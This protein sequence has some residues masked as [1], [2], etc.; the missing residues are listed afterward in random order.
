MKK[1]KLTQNKSAIVDDD[2]FEYLSQW[3]WRYSSGGYVVRSLAYRKPC[4]KY[5][6][7]SIYMHRLVNG[8]PKGK[9]TDHINGNKKDNRKLNLR[10]CTQSQNLMN[11]NGDKNTSSKYKGV[12]WDKR[13][14]KWMVQITMK[15]KRK[16]LGRFV[17]EIDAAK[18]YDKAAIK[19]HREFAKT[20]FID[21]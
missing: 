2:D 17:R 11:R 18:A 7:T 5:T 21:R 16:S 20:N 10:L 4:G 8:T 13:N 1:I 9:Y 19:H 12:T 15:G 3:N 6:S 14:R